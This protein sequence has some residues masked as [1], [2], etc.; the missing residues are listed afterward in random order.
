[1]R[2]RLILTLAA[3]SGVVALVVTNVGQ[4]APT[5]RK[6]LSGSVGP[7]F[8]IS[9]GKRAV[10]HGKFRITINDK[11]GIHNFHLTGPGVNKKTSVS[12]TGI[13]V[14]LVTLKKGTYKFVC[15]PHRTVM[16]GTLRVT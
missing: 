2:R 6:K 9:M 11:S 15:D 16:K 10:A 14:W 12:G 7:G 4:A 8:V 3:L 13:T 1:M 5:A